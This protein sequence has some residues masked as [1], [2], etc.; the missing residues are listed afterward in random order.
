MA[1]I[2]TPTPAAIVLMASGAVALL[3]SFLDF[4][5]AGGDSRSAWS[6]GFGLFPTATLMALFVVVSGVVIALT[7]FAGVQLPAQVAGFSWTQIHLVL[8]FF[9]TLYALSYLVVKTGGLDREVGF[10]LVLVACIGSLVGAILLRNEGTA[11]P[12]PGGPPPAA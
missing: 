10:W 11:T 5:G 6:N 8:G 2:K 12:G 1:E 7:R 4:F 9:A 3:G